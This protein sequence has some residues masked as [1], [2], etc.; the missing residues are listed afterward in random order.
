VLTHVS[1]VFIHSILGHPER[2]WTSELSST[3]A[4][5]SNRSD[6]F[7]SSFR[8]NPTANPTS[9]GAFWP[10]D[11]VPEDFQCARVLTYGY[12]AVSKHFGEKGR[13]LLYIGKDFLERLAAVRFTQPN[14][15]VLF[16]AHGVGGLVL[17]AVSRCSPN[18]SL[19]GD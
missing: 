10:A 17:K 16:V 19:K 14:R 4:K 5:S 6:G 11:F 8:K 12:H 1:I 2:S 7:L 9:R 15:P 3:P 13:S 18:C